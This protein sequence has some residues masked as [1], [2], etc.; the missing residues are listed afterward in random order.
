MRLLTELQFCP[1]SSELTNTL[2]TQNGVCLFLFKPLFDQ[3]SGFFYSKMQ[4]N[5]LKKSTQY[6]NLK[7]VRFCAAS[8]ILNLKI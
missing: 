8:L 5:R 2:Q 1:T 4:I 7:L 3:T 6:I